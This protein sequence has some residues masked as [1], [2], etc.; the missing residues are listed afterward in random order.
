MSGCKE[1][2]NLWK[3]GRRPQLLVRPVFGPWGLG[4]WTVSLHAPCTRVLQSSRAC[5]IDYDCA[6]PSQPGWGSWAG[7]G[8]CW[9]GLG[10]GS[11]SLSWLWFWLCPQSMSFVDPF[12]RPYTAASGLRTVCIL[13]HICGALQHLIHPLACSASD[14]G[15]AP[16]A[17]LRGV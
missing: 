12:V 17:A 7:G 13:S 3:K 16:R 11:W 9:A 1:T 14:N 8:R 10:C 5:M 4:L 15:V 2:H 6:P